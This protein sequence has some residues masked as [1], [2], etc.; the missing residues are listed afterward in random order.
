MILPA[1]FSTSITLFVTVSLSENKSH[2]SIK[3]SIFFSPTR[4]VFDKP[5]I[6]T[7]LGLFFFRCHQPGFHVFDKN[8]IRAETRPCG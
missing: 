6:F 5:D 7:L 4:S 8:V 3:L 2:V 1:T